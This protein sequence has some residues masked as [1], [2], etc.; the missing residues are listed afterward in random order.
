MFDADENNVFA[1]AVSGTRVY[2]ATGPDGKV[3][4]ID[5]RAPARP[6]FDPRRNTSGRWPSTAPDAC[7]SA[8]AI[9]R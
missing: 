7:G 2:A 5:G 8:P 3:Y 1:I 6:F 9:P 4:V